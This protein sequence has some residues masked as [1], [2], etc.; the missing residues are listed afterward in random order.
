MNILFTFNSRLVAFSF[1]I[2]SLDKKQINYALSLGILSRVNVKYV[3][4]CVH[5]CVSDTYFQANILLFTFLSH[6]KIALN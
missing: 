5:V 1:I 6:I 2:F 4:V 3:R